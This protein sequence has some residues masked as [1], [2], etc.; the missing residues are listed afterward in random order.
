M[1]FMVCPAS[2]FVKKPVDGGIQRGSSFAVLCLDVSGTLADGSDD[3]WTIVPQQPA[4]A[5]PSIPGIVTPLGY[6]W[7]KLQ[8]AAA[9][10]APA[11]AAP[12]L[13]TPVCELAN[14]PSYMTSPT[15]ALGSHLTI[16]AG[17]LTLAKS[18]AKSSAE[19]PLQ[20]AQVWEWSWSGSQTFVKAKSKGNSRTRQGWISNLSIQASR[21]RLQIRADPGGNSDHSLAVSK[22]ITSQNVCI[23]AGKWRRADA[24]G[25]GAG[26]RRPRRDARD[27]A[28]GDHLPAGSGAGHCRACRRASSVVQCRYWEVVLM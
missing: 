17:T 28:A 27:G 18:P 20:S 9:T 24:C 2:D 25:P 15:D 13:T 19:L 5:T 22:L 12:V 26:G 8:P 1:F 16:V 4:A 21:H 7:S 23:G 10:Y 3:P 14:T 6:W 11:V